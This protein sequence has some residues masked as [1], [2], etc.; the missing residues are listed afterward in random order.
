M[1]FS[2][3][4]A[5]TGHLIVKNS[6][7]ILTGFGIIGF[8]DTVRRAVT[9]T[10]LALDAIEEEA[11][12]IDNE[13]GRDLTTKEIIKVSWKFYIPTVIEALISIS[14]F[15]GANTINLNRNAALAGLYAI[16]QESLDRYQRKLIEVIG[17]KKADGVR[18][19]VAQEL[20]DQNPVSKTE[21]IIVGGGQSLCYDTLSGRYFMSDME[22]IRSAV[23]TFNMT[24][25]NDM[26][27]C[28]NDWYDLIGLPHTDI[29]KIS[30]WDVGYGLLEV[31]YTS[32]IADDGR[33]AMV[34][35]YTVPR[36]VD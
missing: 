26:V 7:S 3:V 13:V 20:L 21:V 11:N 4:L 1:D 34:L 30:G 36:Y 27:M 32:K 2:K 24:L 22:T 28:V 9:A 33:P 31:R 23:N 10:G 14:C 29:G 5:K 35:D 6:P 15:V 12:L 25:M 8:V 17:A 16:T 18:G 19:A